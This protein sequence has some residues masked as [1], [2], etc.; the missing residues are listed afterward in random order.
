MMCTLHPSMSLSARGMHSVF[1]R[2]LGQNPTVRPRP[3]KNKFKTLLPHVP[4]T[5]YKPRKHYVFWY[6][7]AKLRCTTVSA[8][9]SALSN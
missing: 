1:E 9:A 5:A 6:V 3:W 7:C 8:E 2:T 4:R